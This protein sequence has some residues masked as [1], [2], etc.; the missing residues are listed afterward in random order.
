MYTVVLSINCLKSIHSTFYPLFHF[1]PFQPIQPIQPILSNQPSQPTD[2]INV[3]VVKSAKVAVDAAAL[4][5]H[6]TS[7]SDSSEDEADL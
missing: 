4:I 2:S 6:F 3:N 7:K 1:N 5:L